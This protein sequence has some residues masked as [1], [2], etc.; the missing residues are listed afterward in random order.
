MDPLRKAS[1]QVGKYNPSELTPSERE[2][3]KLVGLGLT[4]QEIANILYISPMTVRTHVKRVH[5]KTQIVGRAK[6]AI[7]S[8]KLHWIRPNKFEAAIELLKYRGGPGDNSDAIRIL[9]EIGVRDNE[10]NLGC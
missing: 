10:K 6:L 9:Q 2:V 5:C 1:P 7:E 3:Y 4:N 8:F